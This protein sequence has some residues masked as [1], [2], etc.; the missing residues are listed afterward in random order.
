MW[1]S[2][3]WRDKVEGSYGCHWKALCLCSPSNS[4]ST[5]LNYN[6]NVCLKIN[7]LRFQSH[8][9]LWYMIRYM[10]SSHENIIIHVVGVSSCLVFSWWSGMAIPFHRQ[11]N[12][13]WHRCVTVAAGYSLGRWHLMVQ[14]V[15][16]TFA[17]TS[18]LDQFLHKISA[19]VQVVVSGA[20]FNVIQICIR[21]NP[22]RCEKECI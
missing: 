3:C 17:W 11:I 18:G 19:A 12:I 20:W 7:S 9:W 1:V 15:M 13:V 16:W 22:L 14:V 21:M 4:N 10:R 5:L 2:C 6:K 8:W